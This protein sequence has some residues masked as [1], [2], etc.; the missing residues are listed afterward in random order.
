MKKILSVL[1][2][3][4]VLTAASSA[5]ADRGGAACAGGKAGGEYP[6][7]KF[8]HFQGG[9]HQGGWKSFDKEKFSEKRAQWDERQKNR[10]EHVQD[11]IRN[12]DRLTQEQK[13]KALEFAK[14]QY[15]KRAA[16]KDQLYQETQAQI[17]KIKADS[18][19]NETQKQEAIRGYFKETRSK[20]QAFRQDMKK[21]KRAFWE[22]AKPQTA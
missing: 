13:E 19:L 20:A 21:E 1:M 9:A 12:N 8:R 16:F 7:K 22:S 15:E 14:G 6:G 5:Y 2:V 10:L 3:L 11:R 17:E 18:S 4:G